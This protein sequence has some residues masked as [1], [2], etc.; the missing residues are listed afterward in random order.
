MSTLSASN[1]YWSNGF[2]F[3]KKKDNYIFLII[4]SVLDHSNIAIAKRGS[5]NNI[6]LSLLESTL[7]KHKDLDNCPLRIAVLHHH[8]ILH[9]IED[10]TSE[11]VLVNGDQLLD[12]LSRYKFSFVIHGHKHMPRIIRYLNND[13]SMFILA[14]GSFSVFLKKLG[15]RTRNLFHILEISNNGNEPIRGQL[16]NWEFNWGLGWNPT[17]KKSSGFPRVI[18]LSQDFSKI[19]YKEIVDRI[20]RSKI[21]R[22]NHDELYK[23]FPSFESYLP[24]EVDGIERD[25]KKNHCKIRYDEYGLIDEIG[26]V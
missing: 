6:N 13:N 2:A 4:N 3:V 15:S 20:N 7:A 25:L 22:I 21:H 9:S 5:F 23:L 11:D 1:S 24:D 18:K 8:P 10:M 17:S 26:R 19:N 12:L 16:T 14:S